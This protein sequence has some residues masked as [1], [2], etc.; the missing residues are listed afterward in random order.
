MRVIHAEKQQTKRNKA[1][2]SGSALRQSRNLRALQKKTVSKPWMR[3]I[4]V[5]D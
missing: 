2:R 1:K 4:T 3:G 5:A